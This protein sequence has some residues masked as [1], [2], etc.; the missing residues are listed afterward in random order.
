ML[1]LQAYMTEEQKVWAWYEGLKP[2]ICN[3]TEWDPMTKQRMATLQDAQSAA[4]AVDG[5]YMNSGAAGNT[6]GANAAAGASSGCPTSGLRKRDWHLATSSAVEPM[7]VDKRRQCTSL[8]LNTGPISKGFRQPDGKLPFPM[9][10]AVMKQGVPSSVEPSNCNDGPN[11]SRY[12]LFHYSTRHGEQ[13]FPIR[14]PGLKEQ[15][16]LPATVF[17]PAQRRPDGQPFRPG[18]G[19]CG[20]KGCQQSHHW[21]SCPKLINYLQQHPHMDVPMSAPV[22]P[23]HNERILASNGRR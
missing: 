14:L 17:M 15:K 5:F 6:T 8:S 10:G 7:E 9:A 4:I 18:G 16:N 12:V 13:K 1:S 11:R 2:D 19:S 21:A 22:R 3:N 23:A 20:V